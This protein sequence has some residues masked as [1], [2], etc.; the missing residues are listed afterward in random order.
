M[1]KVNFTD[2]LTFTCNAWME[3]AHQSKV[4]VKE[5]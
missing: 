3:D 1:S 4:G 2:V 5:T